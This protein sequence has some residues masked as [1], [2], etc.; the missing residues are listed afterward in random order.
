MP[1]EYS[2][3][4]QDA[5]DAAAQT[6]NPVLR[7]SLVDAIDLLLT[8][9]RDDVTLEPSHRNT[10]K[11]HGAVPQTAESKLWDFFSMADVSFGVFYPKRH[12]IATFSSFEAAAAA[13]SALRSAGFDRKEAM[14]VTADEMLQFLAE[15]KQHSG[16]W[17]K[18]MGEVSR[19]FGTEE[20]FVAKD[21]N[22]AV[23]GA[24]FLAVYCPADEEF[25]RVRRAIAPFE[26]VAIQRYLASGIQSV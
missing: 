4:L 16:A 6:A 15:L 1:L 21:V 12:V 3:A 22:N 23:L 9:T 18:V 2:A 25:E 7:E 26:P 10:E 20:V 11:P 5:R 24:G 19:F 8:D 17:G 13:C 14:A